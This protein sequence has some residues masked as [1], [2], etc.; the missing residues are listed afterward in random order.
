MKLFNDGSSCQLHICEFALYFAIEQANLGDLCS[1]PK[2]IEILL[3]VWHGKDV[4][5][6]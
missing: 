4:T 2:K 6:L 1:I 5:C 3:N